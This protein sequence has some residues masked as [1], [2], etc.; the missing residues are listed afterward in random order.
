MCLS[1]SPSHLQVGLSAPRCYSLK[2]YW[3]CEA[4]GVV[5]FRVN[6]RQVVLLCV[7]LG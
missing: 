5:V 7:L 6:V 2:A 3:R 4:G 1:L